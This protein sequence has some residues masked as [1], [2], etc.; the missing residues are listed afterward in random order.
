MTYFPL[1]CNLTIREEGQNYSWSLN[2]SDQWQGQLLTDFSHQANKDVVK[3]NRIPRLWAWILGDFAGVSLYLIAFNKN[4]D[5]CSGG[6]VLHVLKLNECK[7]TPVLCPVLLCNI[8]RDSWVFRRVLDLTQ[9]ELCAAG[10]KWWLLLENE[11]KCLKFNPETQS[12]KVEIVTQIHNC[13]IATQPMFLIAFKGH[14]ALCL[15]G[16]N[17]KAV[18][19]C[20]A[21][22][23]PHSTPHRLQ[24]PLLSSRTVSLEQTRGPKGSEVGAPSWVSGCKLRM[25][26]LNYSY[27]LIR[28]ILLDIS[29]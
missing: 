27:N 5:F 1:G 12:R 21:L 22:P 23:L 9:K 18:C 24:M 16:W 11:G 19:R 13:L 14:C 3:D 26:L 4:W 29:L 20:E 17:G 15:W 8:K 2:H 28:Q 6:S 7:P 10:G 25:T